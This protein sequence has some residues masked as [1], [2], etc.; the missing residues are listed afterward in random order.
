MTDRVFFFVVKMEGTLTTF[1]VTNNLPY[2]PFTMATREIIYVVLFTCVHR[3]RRE[4]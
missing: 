4:I 3:L 1:N 2:A